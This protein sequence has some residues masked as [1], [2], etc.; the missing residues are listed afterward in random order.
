ML[1][2]HWRGGTTQT[3]GPNWVVTRLPGG[4]EIHAHPD[5]TPEQAAT[6]RELGYGADVAAMT[7]EHDVMHAALADW[8]RF[9]AS[10][11]LRQAAGQD[12]P[13]DVA[14][15]EEAA[16]LALQKLIRLSGARLPLPR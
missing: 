5:G 16:V 11:A 1:T 14:A 15:A 3:V 13:A 2:W 12:V 6:A 8:L 10:F 9:P 7:R 4:A